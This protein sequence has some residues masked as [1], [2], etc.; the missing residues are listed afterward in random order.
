MMLDIRKGFLWSTLASAWLIFDYFLFVT[1]NPSI[2]YSFFGGWFEVPLSVA[3]VVTASYSYRAVNNRYFVLHVFAVGTFSLALYL[4][5][6]YAREFARVRLQE[7]IGSFVQDPVNSKADVSIEERQLM[8][9]IGKQKHTV[10]FETFIPTFRR[11]DYLFVKT[12]TGEKY[13]L[14]MTM[15]WSGKPEISLQRVVS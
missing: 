12:E 2:T 9:E 14:I 15:S 11:M 5:S 13:R 3:A 8:I 7:K 10:K 6:P 4:G 1:G